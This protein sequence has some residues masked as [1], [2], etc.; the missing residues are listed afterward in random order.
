M[1]CDASLEPH[2]ETIVSDRQVVDI[3]EHHRVVKLYKPA[4]HVKHA[5]RK[6]DVGAPEKLIVI[7]TACLTLR[8][9]FAV[10]PQMGQLRV[11]LNILGGAEQVI[12]VPWNRTTVE[13]EIVNMV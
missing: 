7:S 13:K 9:S 2:V 10:P 12:M 8:R 5:L 11:T 3:L 4:H 1:H 6:V